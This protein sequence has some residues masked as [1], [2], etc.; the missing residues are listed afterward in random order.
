[1]SE[2]KKETKRTVQLSLKT[3]ILILAFFLIFSSFAIV[4][5]S[6]LVSTYKSSIQDAESSL[7]SNVIFASTN[8]SNQIDNL[9]KELYMAG[10]N[11]KFQ[12]ESLSVSTRLDFLNMEAALS[13]FSIL[14]I[15]DAKG[16][17]YRGPNIADREYFQMAMKGIPYISSPLVNKTDSSIVMMA[18]VPL[19][20]GQGAMYGVLPYDI[21]NS[22]TENISV[23]K[24]GYIFML[25]NKGVVIKYPNSSIVEQF[26]TFEELAAAENTDS[27]FFSD[28]AEVTEPMVAGETAI[29]TLKLDGED[30]MISFKP[31]EGPEGW[32]VAVIVPK[33]E[34]FTNF[35]NIL[36]V[37]II[38]FSIMI[39]VGLIVI[40][41]LS[42]S[43]S[44]PVFM[45]SN[46]FKKI[47]EGDLKSGFGVEKLRTKEFQYLTDSSI[48]TID[49]L[50]NII[51]DIDYVL[52]S[53]VDGKLDVESKMEYRGDFK[54]IENSLN[55]I[56]KNLNNTI[57]TINVTSNS[58]SS[59]S[60]QISSS[61]K[62]LAND[63]ISTA[64][65]LEHLSEG[66]ENINDKLAETVSDTITANSLS[67]L[68]HQSITDGNRQMKNLLASMNDI[69][70]SAEN[71]K[72]INQ[73]IDDIAFQ[74][75][76]L[77]LN[78]AVEAARAG[79][80]GRG[81][82][83]VADEVRTLANKCA[84]AA[85]NS[86][87]LIEETLKTINAGSRSA[88]ETASTLEK[89]M[90]NVE[91]VNVIISNI[92]DA[93]VQQATAV[94]GINNELDRISS[95]TSSSSSAS[96]ELAETSNAFEMQSSNLKGI[97]SKFKLGRTD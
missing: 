18:A 71:I 34:M 63:S 39:V 2:Q 41:V 32:S 77:A 83:V 46:R 21:F 78:A 16:D 54:S 51:N 13:Y 15:S 94:D 29:T 52:S 17:T 85:G 74:T 6:S 89:V 62:S 38:C 10:N 33:A 9:K 4:G 43:L 86:A 45:I 92:S 59:G 37:C 88:D 75:N 35:R 28:I 42:G 69:T 5:V 31:V 19:K 7:S 64:S 3:L 93:A 44:K 23:G 12:D 14:S 80:A 22:S 81:F 36:K 61:A 60:I 56:V 1:M 24:T 8:T 79:A 58:L 97:V 68:A 40:F 91:E 70:Q 49:Y 76:I 57:S 95:A 27:T 25:D 96:V 26:L 82:S 84:E 30:H 90:E 67:D 47:A 53:I 66:M 87:L 73:T 48:I 55:K 11:E 50:N 65:S 20:N 72:H